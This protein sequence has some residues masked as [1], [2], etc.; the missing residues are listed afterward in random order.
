MIDFNFDSANLFLVL[1]YISSLFIIIC[2]NYNKNVNLP[3]T[4]QNN[5]RSFSL[6]LLFVIFSVCNYVSSDFFH[7]RD[8][9]RYYDFSTNAYNHGEPIYGVIAYI[10]R[11]NYLLFRIIVWGGASLITYFTFRRFSVNSYYAIY[12]LLATDI[13]LFAYSRSILA[14]SIFFL[15]L[16]FLCVPYKRKLLGYLLGV[17]LIA[18]SYQFHHSMIILICIAPIILLPYNK[19]TLYLGLILIPIIAYQLQGL[20][21]DLVDSDIL[22]YDDVATKALRYGER[23]GVVN[24]IIGTLHNYLDNGIVYYQLLLS[25]YILF[26]KNNSC[27]DGLKFISLRNLFKVTIAILAISLIFSLSAIE[28]TTFVVR[29]FRMTM[30]PTIILFVGLRE[31]GLVSIRQYKLI[32]LLGV[33]SQFWS[34]LFVLKSV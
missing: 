5:E 8:I 18:S 20:F 31:M 30:I 11:R 15:G 1:L 6:L 19:L 23:E 16:S 12:F 17:T 2:V 33:I 7:Y 28:S 13:K 3:W 22:N 14:M 10:V 4:K 26:N 25:G 24:N 29:I 34:L 21:Y 32:F 27:Y 9:V